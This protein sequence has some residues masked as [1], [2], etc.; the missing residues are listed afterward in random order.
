MLVPPRALG[1]DD[2]MRIFTL[3]IFTLC[4]VSEVLAAG[5]RPP[6][7]PPTIDISGTARRGKGGPLVT[8]DEGAVIYLAGRPQWTAA[9]LRKKVHLRGRLYYQSY[10]PEARRVG[11]PNGPISQGVMPGSKQWVLRQ[12]RLLPRPVLP[13]VLPFTM[14]EGL[15]PH[16]DCLRATRTALKKAGARAADFYVTRLNRQKGKVRAYGLWHV[17]SLEE[18]ALVKDVSGVRRRIREA[19]CKGA[20]HPEVRII[21]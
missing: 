11:G 10:L 6:S 19:L 14:M 8:L 7:A 18:A 20:R 4:G 1:Y 17:A 16:R 15:R 21:R 2:G 9:Q 12:V 3:V 5:A 13:A